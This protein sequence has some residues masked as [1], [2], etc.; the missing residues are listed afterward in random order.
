MSDWADIAAEREQQL[1]DDALAEQARRGQKHH[2]TASAERCAVCDEPIPEDRRQ[3]VHG[4]QTCI[5]CQREL[6]AAMSPADRRR[7][8]RRAPLDIPQPTRMAPPKPG[9][10]T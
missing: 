7:A 9:K 1:R 6:E 3:A 2:V 5:D 8:L 10:K 4:V